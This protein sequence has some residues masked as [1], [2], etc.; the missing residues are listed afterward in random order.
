M[1]PYHASPYGVGEGAFRPSALTIV[2]GKPAARRGR[3]A[4]D[5][6]ETARPPIQE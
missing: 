5:L 2:Q 1:G 6:H 4:R 3:K